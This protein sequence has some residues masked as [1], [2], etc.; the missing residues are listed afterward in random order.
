MTYDELKTKIR[1]YTE[2]DSNVFTDT[3]IN[4]FIEDAEFRLLREVVSD[5]NR[6]KKP[7]KK[8]FSINSSKVKLFTSQILSKKD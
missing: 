6:I 2:V 3:I 8:V 7:N 1:D 4:G 5:N